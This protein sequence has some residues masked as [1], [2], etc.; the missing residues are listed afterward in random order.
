[1]LAGRLYKK[2]V[3]GIQQLCIESGNADM[4]M[5]RAHV[6][7]RNIHFALDLTIRRVEHGNILAIHEKRYLR[8]DGTGVWLPKGQG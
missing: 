5:Q 3:D 7:I 6:A 2:G 4:Y 1:M 8:D